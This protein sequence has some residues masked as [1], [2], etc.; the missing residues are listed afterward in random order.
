[1]T[2]AGVVT[3][4]PFSFAPP[5][6]P[7]EP[8]DVLPRRPR[9]PE[10]GDRWPGLRATAPRSRVSEQ[11]AFPALHWPHRLF[12]PSPG[13]GTDPGLAAAVAPGPAA[14]VLPR[15]HPWCGSRPGRP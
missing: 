13:E 2:I 11:P 15:I 8:A 14:P 4:P 9:S 5:S 7:A 1:M 6:A 3:G 10:A 12:R